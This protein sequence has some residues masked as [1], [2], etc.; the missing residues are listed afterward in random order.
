MTAGISST[1]DTVQ[2][3][4]TKG[5]PDEYGLFKIGDE[6]ITY[7]GKTATSFT[8]CIR[9][10]SGISS[11]RSSLDP[12]ELVFSDTSEQVHANGSTVQN[13]SALFLKEFDRKLK[14]SFAPG[15]KDVDFVD[16]LDVN[17]LSLIHI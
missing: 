17:N 5:F 6:I 9:G 3:S 7:T 10:F 1:A 11:Y 13:L 14:Y 16:D 12:E 15:L 8:G 4:T 2:V